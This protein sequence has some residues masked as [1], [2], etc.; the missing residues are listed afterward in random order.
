MKLSDYKP[1]ISSLSLEDAFSLIRES[2]AARTEIF[3]RQAEKKLKK[4]AAPKKRKT[5][6]EKR[7]EGVKAYLDE[8]GLELDIEL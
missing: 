8:L 6:E 5:K 4:K 3:Q 2:R 1:S 7:K